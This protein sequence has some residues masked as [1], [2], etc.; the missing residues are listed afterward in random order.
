MWPVERQSTANQH[1]PM[2]S[3]QSETKPAAVTAKLIH[4]PDFFEKMI[5]L[6]H[7]MNLQ[8]VR[9]KKTK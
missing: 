7:Q 1:V 3:S 2:A 8:N 5:G 4:G 9:A 6:I